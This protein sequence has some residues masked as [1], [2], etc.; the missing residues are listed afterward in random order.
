MILTLK[1]K[2]SINQNHMAVQIAQREGRAKET[3]IAQI[4]EVLR[5]AL[6][7]LAEHWRDNPRGVEDLLRRR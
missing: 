1:K 4:K 7:I 6:D 5:C 3:D 2:K